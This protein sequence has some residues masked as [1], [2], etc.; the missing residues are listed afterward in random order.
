M[1]S[2]EVGIA[3]VMADFRWAF[4]DSSGAD[5]GSSQSFDSKEQAE[6]WMGQEWSDLLAAGTERVRL[7]SNGDTLYDMGLRAE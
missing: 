3:A 1:D 7:M 4:R 5:V 6:E 2:H